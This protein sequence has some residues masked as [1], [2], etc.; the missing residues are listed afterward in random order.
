M[1]SFSTMTVSVYF[2]I[3]SKNSYFA[4]P[5]VFCIFLIPPYFNCYLKYFLFHKF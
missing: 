1:K 4:D 5:T 3:T 2:D